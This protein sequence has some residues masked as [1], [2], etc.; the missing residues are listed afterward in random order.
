MR[1]REIHEDSVSLPASAAVEKVASMQ[2]HGRAFLSLFMVAADL[3]V[4]H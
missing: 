3:H 2:D 4:P 1:A